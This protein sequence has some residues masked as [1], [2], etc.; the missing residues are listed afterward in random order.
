MRLE[1]EWDWQAPQLL[2]F[3][4]YVLVSAK[5]RAIR[6]L[7]VMLRSRPAGLS[8]FFFA[9]GVLVVKEIRGVFQSAAAIELAQP[10]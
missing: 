1:L 10:K 4:E 6:P 8:R 3:C 7:K 9:C 2:S 5:R